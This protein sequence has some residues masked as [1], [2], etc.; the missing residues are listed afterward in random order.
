MPLSQRAIPYY[1][2][3]SA[4]HRYWSYHKSRFGREKQNL[5]YNSDSYNIPI[6]DSVKNP[7]LYEIE[8]NNFFRIEGHVGKDYRTAL[9][10]IISDRDRFN[11]PFDVIALNVRPS[12]GGISAKDYTCCFEDL[13]TLYEL[14][15]T[16]LMCKVRHSVSEISSIKTE[17]MKPGAAAPSAPAPSSP[18]AKEKEA[19]AK[20]KA[21][22]V[23]ETNKRKNYTKG[24]Y[25][26]EFADP[27]KDT[28]GNEY[29]IAIEGN[30]KVQ[31][32]AVTEM[33]YAN[34][35]MYNLYLKAHYLYFLD[36]LE[37]LLSSVLPAD[38]ADFDHEKFEAKYADFLEEAEE[39]AMYIY[40]AVSDKDATGLPISGTS[41]I[42]FIVNELMLLQSL[43]M[44]D[45][46]AAL[47]VEMAKRL[48]NL[49]LQQL[50]STYSGKHPGLEHKAGVPKGG[51]FILV[52]T[53][54]TIKGEEEM[55]KDEADKKET[56]K[57]T[58]SKSDPDDFLDIIKQYR[59]KNKDLLS[60][61]DI[62]DIS[63]LEKSF[64]SRVEER[65]DIRVEERIVFADF[66]LPYMCCGDCGTVSY[67]FKDVKP[68]PVIIT[69]QPASS[70]I[71]EKNNAT[72]TVKA[73][74]EAVTYQWQVNMG[75][76]FVNLKDEGGY[77]GSTTNTVNI[78]EAQ[79]TM[80]GYKYICIVTDGVTTTTSGEALLAVNAGVTITTQ[81]L[82]TTAFTGK[83]AAFTV[84]ATGAGLT[85]QWQVASAS[86]GF[87]N[88]TDQEIYSGATTGVLNIKTSAESLNGFQY[89]CVVTGT[90]LPSVTSDV[91]TLT[92][93]TKIEI[94]KQPGSTTI[95][96][97]SNTTFSI[98]AT[99]ATT[100]YRWQVTTD[101]TNFSYITD[102]AVYSGAATKILALTAVPVAFQGNKYRCVVTS[103]TTSVNS[104]EATITVND[105]TAIVKQPAST[106]G[107]A[108]KAAM[109]EISSTGTNITYQWQI[110]PG[111]GF[112]NIT[113]L[114]TYSGVN[115]PTLNI[116]SVLTS[117]NNFTYRCIVTGMCPP[118]LI[119]AIVTLKVNTVIA[120]AKQP[121]NATVCEGANTN[122]QISA[123]GSPLTF[124]WQL[125]GVNITN[126]P[127]FSGVNTNVLIVNAAALTQ[128]GGRFRCVV[129]D[130]ISTAN[131][132][133]AV[134]TVNEAVRI[135]SHPRSQVICMGSDVI[136]TVETTGSGA[137][138]QWQI[139]NGNSFADI[140]GQVSN[141]LQLKWG[142]AKSGSQYRCRVS[143]P[144]LLSGIF[145]GPAT[146][147]VVFTNSTFN[148]RLQPGTVG[149]ICTLTALETNIKSVLWQFEGM[150]GQT[151]VQ[152]KAD[153]SPAVFPQDILTGILEGTI[154]GSMT[155]TVSEKVNGCSTSTTF[156][157]TK[158]I[159]GRAMQ[160][161]TPGI[162]LP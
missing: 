135:T 118:Q 62:K 5:S 98:E 125:N 137:Q 50:F 153:K 143:N 97:G 73:S 6:L 136:F 65:K 126:S 13:E 15:V 146:L 28:I 30:G 32:P 33:V 10:N 54:N 25:V 99:G 3:V 107:V 92:V 66:Y 104:S 103:G 22:K 83:D 49:H 26:K 141:T 140:A 149:S 40:Q 159:A 72:F 44:D 145:S 67:V 95:C 1:Y 117:M 132:N 122:F 113:D 134:L 14:L 130:G 53:E 75:A 89:R 31:K 27:E 151:K 37:E 21:K 36:T 93:N 110:N 43:C 121:A 8:Q 152:F 24:T 34:K 9:K 58:K 82:N 86:G 88:I 155:Y 7:L 101:G 39:L 112:A 158:T 133:E 84:A 48:E 106:T 144:C 156:A 68:N 142:Q 154:T 147:T 111:S 129:S 51:T 46:L 29:M 162:T 63:D 55:T 96:S 70:T 56:K 47:K 12:E 114:A 115:T 100:K 41:P 105:S 120:I 161:G 80:N 108:G 23:I 131:T 16:E 94:T 128:N 64:K 74:V 52:Y 139:S 102:G 109:F 85:Y 124:Q 119:S 59:E 160:A 76:G 11:L 91:A 69:T 18:T 2:N 150:K 138:Y 61:R 17:K 116:I 79:L 157:M 123:V 71:C 87:Q 20:V 38:L 4:L 148:M 81:P 42:I 60:D 78:A 35:D 45:R 77:T 19:E 127:Q 57:R 90:C